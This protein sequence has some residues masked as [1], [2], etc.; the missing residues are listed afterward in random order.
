MKNYLLLT[1]HLMQN[2]YDMRCASCDERLWIALL[3]QRKIMCC[4][5]VRRTL[6]RS[7]E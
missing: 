3:Q 6:K 2:E 7:D 1:T 5:S 4:P